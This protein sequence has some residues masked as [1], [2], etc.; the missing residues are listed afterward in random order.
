MASWARLGPVLL[1]VDRLEASPTA[2]RAAEWV[3]EQT[4]ALR[5]GWDNGRG[6]CSRELGVRQTTRTSD[7]FR[8]PAPERKS[9][10]G[11]VGKEA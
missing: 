5:Y 9:E 2:E 3:L 8:F 4:V 6:D 1:R 11:I 7:P 10:K